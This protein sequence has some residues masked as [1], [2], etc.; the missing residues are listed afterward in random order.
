MQARCQTAT[1][2][3]DEVRFG[4][5]AVPVTEHRLRGQPVLEISALGSAFFDPKHIGC[6]LN[7]S[8]GGFDDLGSA[9]VF[10]G[11]RGWDV[12]V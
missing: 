12:S 1:M 6:V 5:A 10:H 8:L 2:A 11:E 3:G 7:L 4:I 9:V